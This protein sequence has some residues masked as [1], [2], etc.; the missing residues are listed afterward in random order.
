MY[1]I[2]SYYAL[3]KKR[4]A[5][6]GPMHFCP[7]YQLQFEKLTV[8]NGWPTTAPRYANA[9]SFWV[10]T[11]GARKTESTSCN[12]RKGLRGLVA[13]SQMML[14]LTVPP[15][16]SKSKKACERLPMM[17]S[18]LTVLPGLTRTFEF[19]RTLINPFITVF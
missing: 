15:M 16:P 2:R 14:P 3:E 18:P 1:A 5:R 8:P 19:W 9:K 4:P 6:G 11:I 12:P 13:T 10:V 17:M 7:A